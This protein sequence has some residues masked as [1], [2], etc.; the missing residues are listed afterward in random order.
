[1]R[2]YQRSVDRSKITFWRYEGIVRSLKG[3][4]DANQEKSILEA[5]RD[6]ESHTSGEIIVRVE[7]RA[8]RNPV[9]V[10]REAFESLGMRNT[11]LHNGVLFLVS[12]EDRKFVV[13]GDDGINAKVPADFWDKVRDLVTEHFRR[14]EVS[15]GLAEGV[16]LAGEQLAI[17]FPHQSTDVNELPN[18]ISYA[19]EK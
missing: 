4:F 3:L 14:G 13:L 8:G 15:G 6:A 2:T 10:A 19:D 5:I 1:M 18:A 16:R 9:A 7:R 12:V 11:E 17:F